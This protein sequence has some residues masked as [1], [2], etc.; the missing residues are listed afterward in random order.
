MLTSYRL[1][2]LTHR[3]AKLDQL[4]PYVISSEKLDETLA[5]LR[6][7]LNWEEVFY[8]STCNR[9]LFFFYQEDR[10]ATTVGELQ[11]AL[12][13]ESI[14]NL[15]EPHFKQGED[16]ILHLYDVA[17][18]IDSLVVGEREILRQLRHSYVNCHNGGHAGD[19]LRILMQSAVAAAKQVY[20]ETRIGQK[21]VSVVS[22][23]AQRIKQYRLDE[24]TSR[25]VMIGAGQTNFL[26]GTFLLKQ[27]YKNVV[28]ANRTFEKAEELANRFE[29]GKAI[30]FNDLEQ[31]KGGFDLLV[32]C[33]GATHA[34]V[35][36]SLFSLLLD[37]EL[38]EEKVVVDLSIPH[39][40]CKS[41]IEAENFNYIQIDD[42]RKLAEE[43]LNFR[44]GEVVAARRLI[45]QCLKDFR[46]S[47]QQ[48]R[49][50]K[51]M[52][53]VP[54]EIKEIKHK[55]LNQVFSR[56]INE[57]PVETK[58]LIERMMNYMEKKCIGVPMKAARKAI[59][60]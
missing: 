47:V 43:N 11:E 42:L 53:S 55:A 13:I 20:S 4:Q 56:E 5:S 41:V 7:Q 58:E 33:T 49:V 19:H 6:K 21:P 60:Q 46:L 57:L 52:K 34:V 17:A 38:A 23:A 27:G 10:L 8:L 50:E 35:D 2:T 45:G 44:A 22:L 12:E 59:K 30:A 54:N 28:V 16:A 18:S 36:N 24:A 48:R 26:V 14:N 29:H 39:N 15:V 37:G 9:I 1:F 31:Y 25:V 3:D 40:V 32:V 51:A